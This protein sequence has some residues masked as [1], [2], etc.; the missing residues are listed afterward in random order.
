MRLSVRDGRE[1]G[2]ARID[3]LPSASRG[4]GQ[5]IATGRPE[6]PLLRF[7]GNGPIEARA[8]DMS[9]LWRADEALSSGVRTWIDRPAHVVDDMDDNFWI[10]GRSWKISLADHGPIVTCRYLGVYEDFGR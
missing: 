2:R 4:G 6:A 3:R 8:A 10:S 5:V 9:L 7:G 1:S